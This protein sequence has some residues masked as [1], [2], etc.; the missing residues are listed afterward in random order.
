[1]KQTVRGSLTNRTP[2]EVMSMSFAYRFFRCCAILP[3]VWHLGVVPSVGDWRGITHS[4]QETW[5][6]PINEIYLPFYTWHLPHAYSEDS[7]DEYLEFPIVGLG[8]GKGRRDAGDNWHSLY[9]MLFSDSYG[10][11]EPIAGY[12][13]IPRWGLGDSARFGLGWTFFITAR[14]NYNYLPLPAALPLASVEND[15]LALQVAY[16]PG[17]EDFGNVLFF[18]LK[19]PFG[20]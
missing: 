11:P 12:A 19:F 6:Q 10:K 13:W 16:V 9:A 15:H 20:D 5:R 7:R 3:V 18:W 1:M 2:P 4:L 14:A 17:W 8:W